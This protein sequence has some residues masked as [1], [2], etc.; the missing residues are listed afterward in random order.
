MRKLVEN[1]TLDKPASARNAN[2]NASSMQAGARIMR[3]L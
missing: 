2:A 1:L 3:G